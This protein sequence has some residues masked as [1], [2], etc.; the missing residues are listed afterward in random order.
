MTKGGCQEASGGF[1]IVETM[2]VLAVTGMLFVSAALAINGRQNKTEFTTAINALQQQLQQVI[3]ETSSGYY[4]NNGTFTC[5]GDI[6]GTGPVTFSNTANQ[7]GANGGCIFMGK[8]IQFGLDTGTNASTLGILPLVGNQYLPGS[9][10]PILTVTDARPRAASPGNGESGIPDT[11]TTEF[12]QNGLTVATSN[13]DCGVG[14]GGIC[15]T[16]STSGTKQA[17]GIVA[18][19]SGDGKGNITSNDTS[20]NLQP[21]SQQLSLYG[22]ASS[23]PNKSLAQAS[24]YI[25]GTTT[26]YV[27]QLKASSSASICIASATTNQSGLFTIDSG[28]H[29][30]L[31]IKGGTVC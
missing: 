18:F 13:G 19:V 31:T 5:K 30:T 6:T 29:V 25:G 20:G 8:A 14:L 23:T 27:S 15:Y 26:P 7:Q 28:L 1:T 16:D 11:S 3:N 22:V 10:D 24:T 17:T 21:G 4:P 12:M 2:I 9:F